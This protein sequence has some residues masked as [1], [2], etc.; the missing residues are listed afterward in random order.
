MVRSLKAGCDE[1]PR[2]ILHEWELTCQDTACSPGR[3]THNPVKES[4]I[5]VQALE[6]QRTRRDV[7]RM[8]ASEKNDP[9]DLCPEAPCGLRV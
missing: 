2:S 1:F 4:P 3:G 5:A 9:C 7:A 8:G 6:I